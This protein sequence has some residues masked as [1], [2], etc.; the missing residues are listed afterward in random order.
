MTKSESTPES[1]FSPIRI[2]RVSEKVA[3]QIKKA[4]SDGIFKVGDRLPSERDLVE[5]MGVSR[6]SIREAIQLLELQG[7]VE[8]VH[9]GGSVVRNIAEQDIQK[10]IETFLREDRQRVLELTHVRAFM[11]KWAARQA[12]SQRSEE[13]LERMGRYLREM[14]KD[15]DR[16]RVR[17]DIDFKFHSEIAAATHNT[18]FVHLMDSIHQLVKYSVQVHREEVFLARESQEIILN[19]HRK[20][21]SA[22]RN[23]LPETAESAMAEHLEFVVREYTKKFLQAED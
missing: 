17:P 9:G 14:E 1:I 18:I 3:Q 21:F 8:T 4:I 6:P 10:P 22:I 20:I 16:G 2:E 15:F 13:E 23:R 12:A 5:Q 11:E 19:H 7:M